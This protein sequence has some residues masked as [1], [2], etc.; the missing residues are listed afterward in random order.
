[1]AGVYYPLGTIGSVPRAYDIFTAYKQIEWRKNKN[2][3]MEK[4]MR[5]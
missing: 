4:N 1:M 2:K 5:I 3:E